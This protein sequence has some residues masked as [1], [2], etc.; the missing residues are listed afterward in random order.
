MGGFYRHFR[1]NQPVGKP[2]RL[3]WRLYSPAQQRIRRQLVGC[4]ARRDSRLAPWLYARRAADAF[5]TISAVAA[6]PL[7]A[8][9]KIGADYGA[10]PSADVIRSRRSAPCRAP[11]IDERGGQIINVSSHAARRPSSAASM[12]RD[13][14]AMIGEPYAI[15]R[16]MSS[17]SALLALPRHQL[18]G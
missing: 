9:M 17:L 16:A 7:P 15:L 8:N 12:P 1:C 3:R 10:A 14:V 2:W 13:D 6:S 11:R 5:A 4:S 18:A